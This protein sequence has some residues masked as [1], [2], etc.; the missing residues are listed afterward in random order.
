MGRL[1]GGVLLFLYSC[2]NGGSI[3]TVNPGI[4]NETTLADTLPQ[5]PFDTVILGFDVNI[6]CFF[7]YM[8]TLV[9]RYDSLVPYTISEHLIV[10]A[11]PWII[12]TLESTDY[13]RMKEKGIFVYD[14]QAL[15]VLKEGDTIFIPNG[16]KAKRLLEEQ[17]QIVIDLNIPEF[18]LRI[19]SG[20]DTLYTF[21][22]RVGQ[23]KSRFLAMSNRQTDLRTSTGVGTIVRINKDPRY[24]NPVD[25]KVYKVTNRDDGKVTLLPRIP[26]IE[27]ELNGIRKGHLIH[28]TTNPKTLGKA[29]S[30]GCIG[31]READAWRIYYYSPIGTKVV[32][33]YD[34]YVVNEL[35]DTI[36]LKDIYGYAKKF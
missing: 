8:D 4:L 27:P 18:K 1:I 26:W 20:N 24:I 13:Y 2:N 25:N 33:R 5:P 17:K 11:N 36:R 15:Y 21:P 31:V 7:E 9:K 23:N 19:L 3:A 34:L 16:E 29:Y 28:P 35:G 14:Q 10:W 12:D 30:N 32:F 6:G 22:I